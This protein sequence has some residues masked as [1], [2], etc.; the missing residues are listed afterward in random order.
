MNPNR[1]KGTREICLQLSEANELASPLAQ[2][3]LQCLDEIEFL[4]DGIDDIANPISAL[5]REA[6]K[7]GMIFNGGIAASFANNAEYLKNEAAR[8]L[9]E[10]NLKFD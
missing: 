3:V 7:E 10:Y 1:I 8:T 6:E 9:R 2:V 4:R 5:K